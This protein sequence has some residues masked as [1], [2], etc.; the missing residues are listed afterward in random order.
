MSWQSHIRNSVG[1]VLPS[2]VHEQQAAPRLFH[3]V[4]GVAAEN[5]HD[6]QDHPQKYRTSIVATRV[7]LTMQFPRETKP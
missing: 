2:L 5:E 1:Q 7:R 3:K 6:A 4:V